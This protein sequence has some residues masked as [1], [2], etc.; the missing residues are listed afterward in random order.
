MFHK[1]K[2]QIPQQQLPQK[3]FNDV[4]M[5]LSV[6]KMAAVFKNVGH[7]ESE[8]IKFG[9]YIPKNPQNP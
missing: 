5:S 8:N 3:A 6:D 1:F 9:L 2:M 7:F 4:I